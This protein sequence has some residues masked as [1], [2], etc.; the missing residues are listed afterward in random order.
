MIKSAALLL[1]AIWSSLTY[2]A[3][4]SDNIDSML[5]PLNGAENV[6]DLGG[7]LTKDNQ[8]VRPRLV[9]RADSLAALDDT[10][11]AY[12]KTLNLSAITDLRSAPERI[13]APDR[14]PLQSPPIKY[15]TLTINNTAVNIPEL[16]KKIFE[17][18][19]STS[20]LLALT[21]RESYVTDPVIRREWGNWLKSLTQPGN[22]PHLF[23]CTAGKD[24]TGFAA[25][26]LLLTLGVS[27]QQVIEDFLL[28][29]TFLADQ[30]DK[31]LQKIASSSKT[32]V[33]E[34]ALR[35]VLGVT[36]S[37]LEG[38]FATMH[39]S[40]CSIE[41]FIEQ[42]LGIEQKT[43]EKLKETFLEDFTTMSNRLTSREII[44]TFANVRDEATLSD[45]HGTRAVNHWYADGTF[46]NE[47]SNE[48]A[49]GTV[50]GSWLSDNN[51][52]CV[53]IAEGLPELKGD[54]RCSPIYRFK[55]HYFSVNPDGTIHAR[56]LL[57]PIEA[58]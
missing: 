9:Y 30:I 11:L 5:L 46:T 39:S 58:P 1:L 7:Y 8:I 54:R 36:S 28:S 57:S 51:L 41:N 19:L 2:A 43:R 35:Q 34:T 42:G 52:R 26:I 24:R 23:H 29:N 17:G 49:H 15:N 6:R 31:N 37:S 40:Y 55:H 33:N 56:H 21:N 14:L 50:T 20:E 25:A 45:A 10:D 3:E 22:V 16:R 38:A 53:I 48:F 27:E 13:A 12:L 18:R 47:W 44:Q 32:P 4:S